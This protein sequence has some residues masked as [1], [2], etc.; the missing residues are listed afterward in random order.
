MVAI[1]FLGPMVAAAAP[2]LLGKIGGFVGGLFGGGGGD[3]GGGGIGGLLGSIAPWLLG[4]AGAY[5]GYQDHKQ[6]QRDSAY[7]SQAQAVE[8]APT[9]DGVSS[10]GAAGKSTSVSARL[11]K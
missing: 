6:A 10:G 3:S 5:Q 4:G 9:G 8:G 11:L 2:S 1:G 7:A